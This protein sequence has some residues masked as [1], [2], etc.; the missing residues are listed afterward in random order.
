MELAIFR[1]VQECLTNIHRHSGSKTA[2][3]RIFVEGG[4]LHVEVSDQGKG[5]PSERLAEIRSGGGG[6]GVRGMQERLRRLG[7]TMTIESNG[8]G[9]GSGTRVVASVPIP[10]EVRSADTEP[11]QA[12]V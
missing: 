7:G 6:V 8:S 3:I 12:A 1:F 5:I 10:K 11:L 4:S 2:D 9:T